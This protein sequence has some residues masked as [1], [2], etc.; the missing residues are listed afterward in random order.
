MAEIDE[1]NESDCRFYFAG[2]IAMN[3]GGD[4]LLNSLK[5]MTKPVDCI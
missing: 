1:E 3:G 2:L 5:A 4:H